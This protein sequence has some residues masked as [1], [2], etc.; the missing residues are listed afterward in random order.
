MNTHRQRFMQNHLHY[1][2]KSLPERSSRP[3]RTSNIDNRNEEYLTLDNLS[4]ILHLVHKHDQTDAATDISISTNGSAKQRV[5]RHLQNTAIRW[6]RPVH[7]SDS[8]SSSKDSQIS[9]HS[10]GPQHQCD[11][12]LPLLVR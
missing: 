12:S 2:F 1:R 6:W 11:R 5:Q 8:R 7:S 3:A 10:I 4:K 9:D